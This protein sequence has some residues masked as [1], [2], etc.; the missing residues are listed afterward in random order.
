MFFL[1]CR[2]GDRSEFTGKI[3]PCVSTGVGE[4][5][6]SELH[7]KSWLDVV[8]GQSWA[9]TQIIAANGGH[10]EHERN[11]QHDCPSLQPSGLIVYEKVWLLNLRKACGFQYFMCNPVDNTENWTSDRL[12]TNQ[13]CDRLKTVQSVTWKN[14]EVNLPKWLFRCSTW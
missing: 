6:F 1:N 11:I 12:L 10:V 14:S 9:Q 7:R 2:V 13:L 3:V 4:D 8:G 5:T